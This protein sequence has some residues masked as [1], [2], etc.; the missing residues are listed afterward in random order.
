MELTGK[1]ALISGG[2]KG[3]GK[4]VVLLLLEA[5]VSVGV[6]DN[7]SSGLEKLKAELPDIS[8]YDCDISDYSNVEKSVDTFFKSAGKIDILINNA[9]ILFNRPL[10]QFNALGI[11][12]HDPAEWQKVIDVNL[13]GPFY[14]ASCVAAKMLE[15]RTRG[16]I[17]NISSIS[18][19][20]NKGQ[21]AYSAAKAGLNALTA[22]W[23][24]E[25]GVM[26]IRVVGVAPG[27]SDTDSTHSILNEEILKELKT[28]IPLRRLG[29]P[30]EIAKGILSVIENDFF[31]GKVLQLDG[32]MVV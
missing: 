21:S 16:V 27:Y 6:L 28:E 11:E 25:L 32:G 24:K 22:T 13:N 17:V 8:T 31:N 30:Q 9:G 19:A 18:A 20:G 5:G 1:Q 10:V 12:K 7:D 14:L 4:E 3:I 23:A 2:V 29:K 26:R 15:K